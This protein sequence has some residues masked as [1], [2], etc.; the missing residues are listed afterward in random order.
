MLSIKDLN[1][2]LDRKYYLTEKVNHEN[3]EIN[4]LLRKYVGKKNIPDK[5]RKAIEDAGITVDKRWDEIS[6]I[7]PNG[8]RLGGSGR[9][10][11]T[12]PMAPQYHYKD[13]DFGSYYTDEQRA[14]RKSEKNS[15]KGINREPNWDLSI[16]GTDREKNSWDKVDLK[17]YLT[18]NKPEIS[19][20]ERRDA[21]KYP[22]AGDH[23]W[24][25]WNSDYTVTNSEYEKEL[26]PYSDD[27][28]RA[29]DERNKGQRFRDMKYTDSGMKT[30]DEIEA[31][32]EKF[33]QQLLNARK[34]AES[35]VQRYTN[36]INQANADIDEIKA[37]ARARHNK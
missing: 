25:N 2:S 24:S 10:W 19:A 16:R 29:V 23:T 31:E 15:E 33:R 12:G 5:A 37:R 9:T 27:Y 17:G 20:R 34:S 32:V 8:R 6:F 22:G 13:D 21:L 36:Q 18:T 35:S 3:D 26:R 1:E 28:K 4:A 30:D 11:R 14:I 7:G